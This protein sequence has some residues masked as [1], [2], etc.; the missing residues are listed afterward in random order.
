LR[1]GVRRE[2]IEAMREVVIIISRRR[3]KE[4]RWEYHRWLGVE[5]RGNEALMGS[6]WSISQWSSSLLSFPG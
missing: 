4:T 3:N 6:R 5:R 1:N 2:E